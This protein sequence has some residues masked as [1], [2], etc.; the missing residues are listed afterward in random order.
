MK[1]HLI[2]I[3]FISLCSFNYSY[4]NTIFESVVK[5]SAGKSN[6]TANCVNEDQDYFYFL[7]NKHVVGNSNNVSLYFYR[8][9]Y[10]SNPITAEV[11]WSAYRSTEP[12]DMALLKVKKESLG[13]WKPTII[14]FELND[15]L[16]KVGDTIMTIG[17]PKAGWPRA[18]KGH[19]VSLENGCYKFIPTVIPGQS[20]SLLLNEDGTKAIGLIAWYEGKYGKAMSREIIEKAALGK[21]TNYYYKQPYNFSDLTRLPIPAQY[22]YYVEDCGPD[23]CFEQPL[24]GRRPQRPPRSPRLPFNQPELQPDQVLPDQTQ[25]DGSIIF[26]DYPGDKGDENDEFTPPQDPDEPKEPDE[27]NSQNPKIPPLDLNIGKFQTINNRLD[28][29]EK[30]NQEND[31]A[32]EN[33]SKQMVELS[34]KVTQLDSKIQ[35]YDTKINNFTT[36]ITQKIADLET[37]I[38]KKPEPDVI[39]PGKLDDYLKD[40][41]T[42]KTLETTYENL[43]K[44]QTET[45]SDTIQEISSINSRIDKVL[46]DHSNSQKE[47]IAAVL[48]NND[49]VETSNNV[50]YDF[51]QVALATGIPSA[52]LLLIGYWGKRLLMDYLKNLKSRLGGSVDTVPFQT[53]GISPLNQI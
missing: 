50:Y 26:P 41:S 40:T 3:L 35:N 2:Y 46:S 42:V 49:P 24:F 12:V 7:T 48:A 14:K 32:H 16:Y 22:Y 11:I 53:P 4:A 8:D 37:K 45:A 10:E 5:V 30:D 9:G 44:M 28:S 51:G 6:G 21:N 20:G 27:N 29:L 15:S 36:T 17:C 13:G 39:T 38:D 18:Y 52:V 23:G 19:I 25:P 1:K 47:L 31:I 33:I 43:G 34:S